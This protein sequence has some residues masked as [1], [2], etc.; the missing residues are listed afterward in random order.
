MHVYVYMYVCICMYVY[1]YVMYACVRGDVG[2]R[3]GQNEI[4][5]YACMY[6]Y[7]RMCSM[8]VCTYSY[9]MSNIMT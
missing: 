3:E 9:R 8:C 6:V 2:E 5:M 1:A 4:C 7:V